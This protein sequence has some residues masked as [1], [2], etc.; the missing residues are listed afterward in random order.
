M[1][2]Y[3]K[4]ALLALSAAGPFLPVA[5]AQDE[6][7]RP[8]AKP[9]AVL[10]WNE[11]A[12]CAI[13]TEKTPP[14]LA[15]R[16][17]AIVHAAIYDAV[18]AVYRTHRS[19]RVQA[20]AP[21]DTSAEAAAA[22]AAHRALLALY[23][24]RI[25]CFDK[26]LDETLA[27]I[28]EGEGKTNG[29]LLGKDVAE[30][31]LAWRRGDRANHR[32]AYT[33]GSE[34][35]R[36]RPTPPGFKVALMPQWPSVTCFCMKTGSQ[37]RPA[38]PPALDSEA[39]AA[40]FQ[41]VKLL[42]AINSTTR[43]A[44]QTVIA[45]FWADD[46][47]T[48]TPPGHWNRIAQTVAAARGTTL[49]ENA[50]LFALLNLALADAAIVSWDCK[51]K[52][53]VWRPFHGIREANPEGNLNT[54]PDPDWTPLLVTPPFPSYTSGHSTFSGAAAAVLAEFFGT[55][56]VR[57]TNTS[58]SLPGVTRTFA[59]FSA[60]AEEAGKSRIY[61]GIHWEFDNR[62]GLVSGRALGE[63][64]GRRFL[65]PLAPSRSDK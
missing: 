30:R 1:K 14:P 33:P 59:S 44:E 25:D 63:Y 56:E 23:P 60:A 41:E 62:E 48:A 6:A 19:Y 27:D 13:R 55:D 61:G 29:M 11:A 40:S 20:D 28:L 10:R 4:L 65:L 18:N 35:G 34:P 16:N 32:T 54:T 8:R 31:L 46:A 39:Y 57:F 42:G 52:F 12:L 50:R 58:E 7:V 3:R 47:G 9:D 26:A 24:K 36:W 37:F 15:A 51:Y 21:A 22:V 38:A 53:D 49:A 17:L 2:M 64:V 45:R 43:S 5:Q